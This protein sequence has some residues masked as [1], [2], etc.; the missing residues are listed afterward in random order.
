MFFNRFNR[1]NP[2]LDSSS[3]AQDAAAASAP[4]S[5]GDDSTFY[6]YVHFLSDD[7]RQACLKASPLSV[8]V[9][10]SYLWV[11]ISQFV[12]RVRSISGAYDRMFACPQGA[13]T[14]NKKLSLT[15]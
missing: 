4:S 13:K 6:A 3:T 11:L 1:A 10:C 14:P 15:P 7:A 8:Q 5:S 9:G 12:T 2:G